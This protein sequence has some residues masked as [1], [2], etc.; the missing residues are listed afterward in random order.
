MILASSSTAIFFVIFITY[1]IP[2]ESLERHV[3]KRTTD[4]DPLLSCYDCSAHNPDCGIDETTIVKGCHA[5]LVYQ[6][7]FDNSMYVI[8]VINKTSVCFFLFLILR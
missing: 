6:N 1:S 3:Q 5:C 2:C 7:V 4:E 8:I